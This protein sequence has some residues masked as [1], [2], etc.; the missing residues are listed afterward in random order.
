MVEII[1]AIMPSSY[2]ELYDLASQVEGI[3]PLAQIDIMDGRFVSSR[4]WPYNNGFP[5]KDEDF[6]ALSRQEDGLPFWETLDYEI[7]LMIDE[8]ERH[9]MEWMPIGA[10]RLIIHAEAVKDWE[11]LL[12][13]DIMQEGAR[14]IGDDVVIALGI[15]FNPTTDI[16]Q[17]AEYLEY[18]D[19]VQCMGIDKVGFQGQP[20][21][22]K[23]LS[24]INKIRSLYPHMPVSVDGGVNENTIPDLVDAGA[25]R[26]IAGSAIYKSDDKEAAIAH[27]ESIASKDE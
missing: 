24:Q 1:P 3:V 25:T 7:D 22:E 9:L 14:K 2:D 4:S 6:M 26:L 10:S 8:P 17:Y 19:F 5:E 12:S 15:S 20:F 27:L 16:S 11:Q 23:V 18:F 21:D 13:L